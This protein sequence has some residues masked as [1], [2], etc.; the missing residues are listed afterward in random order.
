MENHS[1]NVTIYG[2]THQFFL[3]EVI[4]NYTTLPYKVESKLSD[5]NYKT[6]PLR[7]GSPKPLSVHFNRLKLCTPSTWFPPITSLPNKPTSTPLLLR[8]ML[9][10]WLSYIIFQ[11]MSK[12][13]I[14]IHQHAMF[15]SIQFKL[16][17]H[18]IG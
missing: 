8:M 6:L 3:K 2:C 18:L 15:I 9:E 5:L 7:T 13:I 1:L 12:M 16:V 11:T 17:S 10:I 4:R 14:F